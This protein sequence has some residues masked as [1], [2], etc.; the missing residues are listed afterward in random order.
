MYSS[1][2]KVKIDRRIDDTN[3]NK[4]HDY[5]KNTDSQGSTTISSGILL[6]E[7]VETGTMSKDT[8]YKCIGKLLDEDK[9][10]RK[11]KGEYLNKRE[12]D[13]ARE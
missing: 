11:G 5:I 9:I 12:D 13:G 2:K 3:R 8:F 10:E 6:Q 4:I 1:S 7:F